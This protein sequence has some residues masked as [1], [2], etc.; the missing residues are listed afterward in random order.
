MMIDNK[1]KRCDFTFLRAQ[2]YNFGHVYIE[3]G[4]NSEQS[5]ENR[6]LWTLLPISNYLITIGNHSEHINNHIV[7]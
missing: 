7:S 5:L 3:M 2:T 1:Q 4:K 6:I